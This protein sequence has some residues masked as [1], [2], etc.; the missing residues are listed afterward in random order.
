MC[1]TLGGMPALEQLALQLKLPPFALAAASQPVVALPA[2]HKFTLQ[3]SVAS[4][5]HILARFS[6]P[7]TA[8]VQCQMFLVHSSADMHALLSAAAACID[9]RATPIARIKILPNIIEGYWMSVD[10]TAWRANSAD[11]PALSLSFKRNTEDPRVEQGLVAAVLAALGSAHLAVLTIGS[12]GSDDTWLTALHG[13]HALRSVKV[14]GLEAKQF[15]AGLAAA[16]AGFLPA[17]ATLEIQDVDFGEG[18]GDGLAGVLAQVLE[19]RAHAGSALRV[20]SLVGCKL[21]GAQV[22]RLMEAV[23]RMEVQIHGV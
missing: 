18:E 2:L 23:P 7:V 16:P 1:T 11:R 13:A 3:M 15:C 20:L 4:A 21:E 8:S 6:L 10:V 5:C 9:V 14:A 12:N 22:R 19:Q 17:L